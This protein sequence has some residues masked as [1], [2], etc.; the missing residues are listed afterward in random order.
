MRSAGTEVTN[1]GNT[2]AGAEANLSTVENRLNSVYRAGRQIAALGTTFAMFGGAVTAL[3]V[4][5]IEVAKQFDFWTAKAE[6]ASGATKELTAAMVNMPQGEFQA[7]LE[8]IANKIGALKPQEVAQA[9]YYWAS[10]TNQ[11][12]DSQ[13]KLMEASAQVQVVLQAATI[14]GLDSGT[15]IRGVA[16]V[17]GEYGMSVDHTAEVTQTLLNVTQQTDAEFSDID[18]GLQDGRPPGVL[19]GHRHCRDQCCV[20]LHGRRWVA[21][22]PCRSG[23]CP[24]ADQPRQAQ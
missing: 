11:V 16:Q 18:L 9:F 13:Q 1:F 3:M 24:D 10:A 7:A 8:G 4:G 15:A 22:Y 14:A 20:R 21:W 23:L 12:I 17:L 5:S 2:L 6:A 19:H